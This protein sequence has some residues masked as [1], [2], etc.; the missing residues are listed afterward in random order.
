MYRSFRRNKTDSGTLFRDL[1]TGAFGIVT[2]VMFV[3]LL[4][5]K[6]PAEKNDEQDRSRGNLRV[7]IIWPD[8]M[9]VDIDLW[10]KAP[11]LPPVGY[12]NMNGPILNLVRDDLGTYAD[13]TGINY[14][15]TY[16]RGLPQGQYVINIHWFSNSH[17]A[18]KVPVNVF[19]TIKKDDTAN[20]KERPRSIIKTQ[21]NLT[22]VGQEITVIRFRLDENGDLIPESMDSVP[23]PIRPVTS[24]GP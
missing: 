13:V 7:E 17:N 18:L 19:V 9:D 2:V 16:S 21:L 20:S 5:P 14:E 10:T 4:L 15:T 6:E 8:H 1:I 3:L 12:S 11:G 24:G 23:T 22:W